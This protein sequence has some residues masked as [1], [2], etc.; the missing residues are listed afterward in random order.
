MF[1][2]NWATL[3]KQLS[4]RKLLYWRLSRD[5][6]SHGSGRSR[7]TTAS[8]KPPF[9]ATWRMG[10]AVVRQ[11]KRWMDNVKE[12]TIMPMPELL[13]IA[14]RRKD[15]NRISAE[16]PVMFPDDPIDQGAEVT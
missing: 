14:S 3:L 7:A 4:Y 11:R 13:T 5:R 6:N 15:W 12:W 1:L 8:P 9:R 2:T 16:T 10:D